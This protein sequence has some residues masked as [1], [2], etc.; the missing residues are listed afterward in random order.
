MN[1]FQIASQDK[2]DSMGGNENH[3]ST[4]TTF[5]KFLS[6]LILFYYFHAF[7]FQRA[8]FLTTCIFSNYSH[9]HL[10]LTPLFVR[11]ISFPHL[12]CFGVSK[13]KCKKYS[14]SRS[15]ENSLLPQAY[16]SPK[17]RTD[18][19]IS[20]RDHCSLKQENSIYASITLL[21]FLIC[22]LSYKASPP[23]FPMSML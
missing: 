4:I 20:Y 12:F 1:L 10:Y 16:F 6:L 3:L 22:L 17:Y 14:M 15:H 8:L 18:Q 9:M 7:L 19:T 21:F 11:I 5:P 23:V 13:L 2:H